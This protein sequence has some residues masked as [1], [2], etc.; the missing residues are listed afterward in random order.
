MLLVKPA[1][2]FI[3]PTTT[4]LGSWHAMHICALEL[5]RTRKFCAILSMFW[6]CGSWQLVHSMLP[7][8]SFTAPV[9]SAV[10]PCVARD[11]TRLEASFIG[12]TRLKG[13]EPVSV[14]PKESA[15][16][17]APTTGNCP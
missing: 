6:L 15:L 5:S 8:T 16:F 11:E 3:C 13:C 10:V 1:R 14:V 9:G 12:N 17:K 7:L 4:R 2:G